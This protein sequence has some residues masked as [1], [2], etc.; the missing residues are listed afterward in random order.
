MELMVM[1]PVPG[2]VVGPVGG[3]SVRTSTGTGSGLGS[4]AGV[5]VGAARG[6]GGATGVFV[7]AS[8]A[9]SAGGHH[10]HRGLLSLD[11]CCGRTF[12][13]E[14]HNGEH[15]DA[16]CSKQKMGTSSFS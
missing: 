3:A 15:Q 9:G 7:T 2:S 8:E 12:A 4:G 14:A 13:P 16:D 1:C 6:V 10:R 11:I 5:G